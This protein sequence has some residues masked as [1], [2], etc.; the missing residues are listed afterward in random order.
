MALSIRDLYPSVLRVECSDFERTKGRSG[1]E[2]PFG[3]KGISK[4]GRDALTN[5]ALM[6]MNDTAPTSTEFRGAL[7]IAV[8]NLNW[9]AECDAVYGR[10]PTQP[11]STRL[12]RIT[13]HALRHSRCSLWLAAGVPLQNVQQWMGHRRIATTEKYVHA[14]PMRLVNEADDV[15]V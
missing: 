6:N 7:S 15:A 11:P 13:P 3:S 10:D 8:E 2:I 1:R 9:E 5:V 14:L 12:P 4:V